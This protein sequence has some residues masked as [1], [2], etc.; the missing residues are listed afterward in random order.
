MGSI[1]LK[2]YHIAPVL[3]KRS[4]FPNCFILIH[5]HILR[6]ADHQF[7]GYTIHTKYLPKAEEKVGSTGS[8]VWNSAYVG[9]GKVQIKRCDRP[10][11]AFAGSSI[12]LLA[13]AGCVKPPRVRFVEAI[14]KFA[15]PVTIIV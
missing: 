14:V 6:K 11:S 12:M 13:T 8:S 15:S 1:V 3:P 7:S 5:V 4:H 2:I 9:F 10:F